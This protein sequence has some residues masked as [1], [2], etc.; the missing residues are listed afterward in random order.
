MTLIIGYLT[1]GMTAKLLYIMMI[2][3]VGNI[4]ESYILTPKIIGDKI[5]LHPLWIIFSIFACGS[6]FGI[7]GIFFAI[8]IA[9]IT[10]ILLLNL[11][12]FYKSSKFYR[13]EG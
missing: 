4:C 8:P 10:K 7:I 9:G 2:Y 11:I 1:F 13:L 6:L 3:L 12:K 5:G